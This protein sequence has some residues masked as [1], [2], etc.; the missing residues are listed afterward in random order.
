M[1]VGGCDLF[2]QLLNQAVEEVRESSGGATPPRVDVSDIVV[3]IPGRMYLSDEHIPDIAERVLWYRKIASAY[4][5]AKGIANVSVAAGKL[6]V[7]GATLD[8]DQ[9]TRLK[10]S[11]GRYLPDAK[12]AIIPM[13]RVSADESG[14]VAHDALR[15]LKSVLEGE[16]SD[17]E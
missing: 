14:D 11:G 5:V 1:S 9:R 2:S 6:N 10:R 17:D 3:N 15:Y 8:R 4:S 13:S 7:E 12:K 16:H